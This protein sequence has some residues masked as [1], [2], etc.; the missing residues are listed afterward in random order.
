MTIRFSIVHDLPPCRWGGPRMPD[1]IPNGWK[2]TVITMRMLWDHGDPTELETAF[3]H[4]F[5][6]PLHPIERM[7][8]W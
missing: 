1:K 4:W 5:T 6:P 2:D 8:S 3:I 7:N